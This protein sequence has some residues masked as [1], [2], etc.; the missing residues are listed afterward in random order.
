MIDLLAAVEDF[1]AVCRA[2][3]GFARLAV[4]GGDQVA[5]VLPRGVVL[6]RGQQHWVAAVSSEHSQMKLARRVGA[7]LAAVAIRSFPR[8]YACLTRL[9]SPVAAFRAISLRVMD[10][11][12]F[13]PHVCSAVSVAIFV[14]RPGTHSHRNSAWSHSLNASLTSR[15]RLLTIL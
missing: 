1:V 2:D 5:I 10:D 6:R 3:H 15:M 14:G 8:R 4:A 11:P 13:G 7:R 9:G 12:W